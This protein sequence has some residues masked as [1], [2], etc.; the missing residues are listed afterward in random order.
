MVRVAGAHEVAQGVAQAG[1]QHAACAR[2]LAAKIA[3]AASRL[4]IRWR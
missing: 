1:G 4:L 3:N 2:L